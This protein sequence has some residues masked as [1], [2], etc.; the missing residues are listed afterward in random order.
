VCQGGYKK[1]KMEQLIYKGL[2]TES[3]RGE[4]DDALF[5]GDMDEP[6]AYVFEEEIQGKQVSVRYFISDTEKTKEELTE[7]LIS[8][9]AGSVDADYGDR[10]SDITGYLWTDEELNV[11]GHDL[12]EEL[13]SNIGKYVYMEVD[14]HE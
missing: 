2:I 12:L 9:I 4:N 3:S 11:G 8:T 13:R 14:V 1:D 10:Y 7:N 5:V 6:I